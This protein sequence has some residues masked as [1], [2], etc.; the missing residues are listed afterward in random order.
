MP[1]N[2]LITGL[3]FVSVLFGKFA[4]AMF[5][6]VFAFEFGNTVGASAENACGFIFFKHNGV[7]VDI[8]FK[9]VFYFNVKGAAKFD[10]QDD[11]SKFH[12]VSGGLSDP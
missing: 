6:N 2:R 4:N 9:S 8:Y 5:A 1:R 12:R 10:G 7:I 3:F 11:S